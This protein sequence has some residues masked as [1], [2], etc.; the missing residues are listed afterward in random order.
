MLHY[1][2]L[3]YVTYI[4]AYLHIHIYNPFDT[5]I[6]PLSSIHPYI[7][8]SIHPYIQPSILPFVYIYTYFRICM[9][10]VYLYI[11]IYYIFH[12]IYISSCLSPLLLYLFASF[13]PSGLSASS[14]LQLVLTY[15][16]TTDLTARWWWRNHQHCHHH[17]FRHHH[18]P[19]LYPS[20]PGTHHPDR[21]FSHP[22]HP[23]SCHPLLPN[24]RR[25]H[26]F[27]YQ[28]KMNLIVRIFARIM[29][30]CTIVIVFRVSSKWWPS[31]T[32]PLPGFTVLTSSMS[33]NNQSSLI[34]YHYQ[35]F[36]E[37]SSVHPSLSAR[38]RVIKIVC[39]CLWLGPKMPHEASEQSAPAWT[40]P[41]SLQPLLRPIDVWARA[42]SPWLAC[43]AY[44]EP[45][46]LIGNC[47][48]CVA[49]D[50]VRLAYLENDR[51]LPRKSMDIPE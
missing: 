22:L 6:H 43:F 20:R 46:V 18:G 34:G 33:H 26:S 50:W 40:V 29:I 3:H 32:P 49:L 19:D 48:N 15:S 23:H 47:W 45:G 21:Y 36:P 8:P 41:C 13:F 38:F 1:V 42:G 9:S 24:S 39:G 12:Y 16:C 4:P 10:Y 27:H 30:T 11:I 44:A 31:S 2:A 5:Y 51:L 35:C 25:C 28:V 14:C 7:Q 37:L 17:Y